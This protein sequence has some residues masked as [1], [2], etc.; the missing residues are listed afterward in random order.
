MK[1]RGCCKKCKLLKD[2]ICKEGHEPRQGFNSSVYQCSH[3]KAY[4]K[5]QKKDDRKKLNALMDLADKV[6]GNYIRYRDEGKCIT[7]PSVFD[8][9]ERT[10]IH[11]GHYI[12]RQRKAVRFD[13]K[14]VYGQCRNCNGK[15]NIEG[16]GY[17]L[18]CLLKKGKLT[19]EEVNVLREKSKK[20]KKFTQYELLEL[21]KVYDEKFERI[22]SGR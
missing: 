12:S 19:I 2:G 20:I 3:K 11:A 4:A 15:Q 13:E 16:N 18:E 21:I 6:F 9:S 10:L 5:D 1:I 7:C 17:M 14:N 22:K 8:P